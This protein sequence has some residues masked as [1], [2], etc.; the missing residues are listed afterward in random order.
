MQLVRRLRIPA[1]FCALAVLLCEL[2][3]RPYTTM[4]IADDGPYILM[5][6]TLATTGRIAYNGWGA[7]MLGWQLYLGAALVKL[8]GF[9]FTTVRGSTVLVAMVMAFVLQRTLVR[10]GITEHN[11]T[12]GTVALVLSPLYLMLSVTYMTD[13]FGLFAIVICLYGCIRALQSSTSRSTI[14]WLCFAVITNALCGTSRQIAWLGILVM[15]PSTLWLLRA[16][17]RVLFAGAAANLAGA[18]FILVCMH[19]LKRQPY[20]IPEQV[21]PDTFAIVNTLRQLFYTFIDLPFLLLPVVVVFLPSLRKGSRAILAALSV[22]ALIYTPLS[23]TTGIWHRTSCCSQPTAIGPDLRYLR[24]N[25][26]NLPSRI[27]PY[28]RA[29]PSD[30]RLHRRRL[31]PHRRR[32][33]PTSDHRRARPSP[34]LSWHQLTVLLPF[35]HRVHPAPRSPRRTSTVYDRYLLAC[36]SSHCSAS[37]AS[38]RNE[39]S[40]SSPSLS[41]LLIVVM[42]VYGV[43]VTHNISPSIALASHSPPSSAPTASQ[44]PP[45]TAAG[46]L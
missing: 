13:I 3:S 22:V 36:C 2:I 46:K 27:P 1:F 23:C 18:V 45:S 20:S 19:W 33:P 41:I 30:H 9:S 28:E 12:L 7:P 34:T 5:A 31:R 32:L 38:T 29:S 24:S 35:T 39:S 15:V 42:A 16:Q 37:S 10:A 14:L 26:A 11:A 44:T 6:R 40:R 8:F 17:R 4:G 43:A 21:L 25:P